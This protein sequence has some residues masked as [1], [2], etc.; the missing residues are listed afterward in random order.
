MAD[1]SE[2]ERFEHI[3]RLLFQ[4]TCDRTF[5]VHI[6]ARHCDKRS[7]WHPFTDLE[8]SKLAMKPSP[9]LYL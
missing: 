6:R 4:A 8:E 5:R 7:L 9:R 2:R 3:S 1:R